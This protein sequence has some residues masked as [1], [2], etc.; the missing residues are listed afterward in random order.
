MI[1][2]IITREFFDHINSL[3][4]ALTTFILVALMVT[5][6]V[7]HLGRH[8]GR[9][10]QYSK[11]VTAARNAVKSR[12]QLYL[13][14]Q[15]GPGDF[16]KRPSPLAFIADGGEALLPSQLGS[17]GSWTKTTSPGKS[18]KSV[19][20]MGYPYLNLG[21]MSSL[22]PTATKIDWVFIITYLLSFLPIL[23]TFDAL[24]GEREQGTLRLCLANPISRHALLLGKFIGAL[25]A[26]L[27]PFCFAVLLNLAILSTDTWTHLDTA[28]WGRLGLI[29]LIA[30]CYAGIF[31]AVGLIVSAATRESRLTLILLL[32]IWVT[33]VVF[34]PSTLGTL[35]AKWMSP[36]QT[37]HQFNKAKAAAL[38]QAIDAPIKQMQERFEKQLL[39]RYSLGNLLKMTPAEAQ[40]LV[41]TESAKVDDADLPMLAEL[42]RKDVEVRER[43]NREH[44]AAQSAQVL[45]ARAIT[46]FSPAA[47]VQYALESM[48][49]TGFNRHLHFL[50]SVQMHIRQFRGFIE[51]RERADAASLHL[52]GIPQ[53][54]SEKPIPPQAI[55][56]FEDKVTFRDTLNTAMGDILLLVLLL[57]GFLLGAFLVFVRSEV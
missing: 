16:H 13:L 54:M 21:A 56:I 39:S 30:S 44:L 48:A 34:M 49:G 26:V 3:R 9:V 11:N 46:R 1:W 10:R 36:V 43:F 5:N 40:A 24:S 4:F 55:P 33:I 27:L 23:F 22:R 57:G 38:E 35:A 14:L 6:A 29:V 31:C 45:R 18:L 52:I 28:T 12:T 32:L 50:E 20:W 19:W 53:G 41:E 42:V 17:G 2:H 37:Q 47:T 8:S 15:K 25:L 7:V 51:E